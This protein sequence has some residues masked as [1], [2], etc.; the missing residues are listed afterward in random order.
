MT[1][2]AVS[3]LLLLLRLRPA[4]AGGPADALQMVLGLVLGLP[5]ALNVDDWKAW[6]PTWQLTAVWLLS[7][8]VVALAVL[9]LKPQPI[10]LGLGP[11]QRLDR[12]DLL[13]L[14]LLVGGALL[15]RVPGIE[16]IPSGV[17]PDEASLALLAVDAATGV[18]KDPFGTGWVTHPTLQFFVHGLFIRL[19]G[20]TFLAM[21]LPS[22]IVGS[23][24]VAML[25]LLAR[26]GYGRRVAV[27]VGMLAMGSNVAIHFS[28][29][30]INN[31]TDSLFVAWTLAALWMAGASGN[32]LAYVLAGAGL[33]LSQYYYFGNRAIPFVVVAN[34]V[35]WLIADWRG[36]L[37]TRYLILVIFLV[38]LVVAG[39][40]IGHWVRNPGSI[41]EHLGLTLP[42][43]T[44]LQDKATRMNLPLRA[45]WWQ[46]IYESLLVFTVVP[47][48]GSFYHPG[49]PMLH[50]LQAPL[51]LIG[52][53]TI[54]ARWRR[55]INQGL[56]AWM[57]VTLTLGSVLITDAATFHR[58]LG[59]L[60]A[61]ILVVAIG[62]DAG[63]T[64]LARSLRW[65]PTA[66]AWLA[67]IIVVVLVAVDVHYYFR[68]YNV[69][70]AYKTP[71]Q[72]AVGI[73]AL[74]YEHLQGQG[75]F[76]L[77]THEGIDAAGK[78]YHSPIDYVAGD[79]FKGGV[80]QVVDQLDTTQPLYFYVLPDQAAELP[81]LMT[82]FPGGS[83]KE[84]R[85]SA[86]GLLLVT[87]YALAPAAP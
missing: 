28:R 38:A 78:I 52:V 15:L 65:P 75:T 35:V 46:Q 58:L 2:V 26:V 4:T 39:P 51:F 32:P 24:A 83:L 41:T 8:I 27:L 74:E 61:A 29:L 16:T 60:P 9:R 30:G 34:L 86:D 50:P 5:L 25:Y 73:A 6:T 82:R 36:V 81:R 71:T 7:C 22:A 66:G 3:L 63:A 23:L 43:S 13:I 21:R 12:H 10:E 87:R 84:Y 69:H 18:V 44:H 49:Q 45:L 17:D 72:E 54:L 64:V 79:V 62:V 76:V 40:L 56:L 19:L 42:F 67:A 31:I 85:R 14:L 53:V 68:I 57:A 70:Q 47:D 11:V 48:W 59:V 37:R 55:P 20:R 33:G 77:Y 80:P 1:V